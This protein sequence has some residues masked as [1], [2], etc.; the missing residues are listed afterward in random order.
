MKY[1]WAE[2]GAKAPAESAF[3][4]TCPENKIVTGKEM[5]GTYYLWVLLETETGKKNICGSNAFKFDNTAPTAELKTEWIEEETRNRLKITVSNAQDEHSGVNENAKIYITPENGTKEE[6]S[7]KLTNGTGEIIVDGLN[8]ESFT[9]IEMELLDKSNNSFNLTKGMGRIYL[10]KKGKIMR[11]VYTS[12]SNATVEEQ[13]NGVTRFSV[14]APNEKGYFLGGITFK[15][16][17]GAGRFY[18]TWTESY[19][20]RYEWSCA[21]QLYPD[22]VLGGGFDWALRQELANSMVSTNGSHPTQTGV[23]DASFN[24]ESNLLCLG[25]IRGGTALG[26]TTTWID[27]PELYVEY[28]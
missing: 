18:G 28:I 27:V 11:E 12:S 13:P 21:M 23:I 24:A 17:G 14:T 7:I 8:R 20:N 22:C 25:L 19:E 6:K 5:T 10:V 3:I 26:S 4:E 2:D 15:W 1:K 9:K 16:Y